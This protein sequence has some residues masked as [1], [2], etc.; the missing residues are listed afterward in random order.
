MVRG[1]TNHGVEELVNIFSDKTPLDK[2]DKNSSD[3]KKL[4]GAI[5]ALVNEYNAKGSSESKTEK[6]NTKGTIKPGTVYYSRSL[7]TNIKR[8]SDSTGQLTNEKA[9]DTVP[10]KKSF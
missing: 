6:S 7:K 8:T 5:D 3:Y 10:R 1:D 9:T 4:M 2:V